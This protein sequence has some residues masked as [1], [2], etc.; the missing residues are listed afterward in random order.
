MSPPVFI[1]A[2]AWIAIT[3]RKDQNHDEAVQVYTRL[4]ASSTALVTTTWTAYEALTVVKSR[5]G[6]N[7]AQQLWD[8]VKSK[9]IVDLVWIDESI[10]QSALQLFWQYKDKTWGVV[11]CSSLIVMKAIV[12]RQ[13]FAYDTHFIEASRQFGF[14]IV[15]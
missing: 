6:F 13:A 9:S 2:S 11:D 12:C 3:N 7:Q 5:L 4:L 8:R 14:A 1:D 15:K 10:E